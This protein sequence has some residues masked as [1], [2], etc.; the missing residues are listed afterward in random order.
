MRGPGGVLSLTVVATLLAVDAALATVVLRP[1]T[2]VRPMAETSAPARTSPASTASASTEPTDKTPTDKAPASRAP[3]KRDHSAGG[4]ATT[5]QPVA[6]SV[7]V[8]LGEGVVM[9]A[10]PVGCGRTG[11][12]YR[13]TDGGRSWHGVRTPAASILRI[14]VIDRSE[15]WIVGADARCQPHFY[16]TSNGGQSWQLRSSTAGA[17]HRLPDPYARRLHAP[18]AL[19]SSPCPRSVRILQVAGLTPADG[20]ALCEDGSIRRSANGGDS[21]QRLSV[22]PGAR[23]FDVLSTGAAFVTVPG[24]GCARLRVKGSTDG[25]RTWR[26]LGCVPASRLAPVVDRAQGARRL[27]DGRSSGTA[28]PIGLAFTTPSEG[29]LLTP[30]AVFTTTDGGRTWRQRSAFALVRP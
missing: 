7:P 15:A 5:R 10:A 29:V 14:R 4:A 8:D 18:T 28:G 19:V 26:N 24:A 30:D 1:P 6:T 21:W 20:A 16:Q 25:G 11:G 27:S 13:S 12:L 23:A 9:A 3:V 17:W 2:P 22:V